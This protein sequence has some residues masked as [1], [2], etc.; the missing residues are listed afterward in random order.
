M[1]GSDARASETCSTQ[2]LAQGADRIEIVLNNEFAPTFCE[3][4]NMQEAGMFVLVFGVR[5]QL[6]SEN[7]LQAVAEAM[8]CEGR[9]RIEQPGEC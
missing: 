1:A 6:K 7:V 8:W 4:L 5:L 2:V 9:T 3:Q